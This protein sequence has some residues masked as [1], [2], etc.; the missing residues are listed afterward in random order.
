MKLYDMELS[1][2]CYKV[3]LLLSLLDV[4]YEQVAVDLLNGEQKSAE[5]LAISPKGQVPALDDGGTVINDS[6]AILVYLAQK[7]K[8]EQYWPADAATQAQISYW[9]FTTANEIAHGPCAAR[10]VKLFG[11]DIDYDSA[12]ARAYAVFDLM[13]AHLAEREFLV[14]SRATLADIA[15]FPY[16]AL[17]G[18][19]GLSLADYPNIGRWLARIKAL[20]NFVGMPGVS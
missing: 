10:L 1:G 20:P 9:L 14:G 15:A 13:E 16:I 5:Y 3:R 17:S 11:A 8:A 19:G 4:D 2:N 6:Q 18:D 7:L 12:K